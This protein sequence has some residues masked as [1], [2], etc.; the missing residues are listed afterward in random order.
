MSADLLRR[1]EWAAVRGWPALESREI[2]GWL[3][4]F[5]SG[6][7]IRANSVAALNYTGTDVGATIETIEA[8]YR[9]KN[10][11]AVFTVS[12]ASR[13]SD[14]DDRLAACGY[15]RGEDHITM[16]RSVLP[17][18]TLPPSCIANPSPPPGW[19]DAYLSGLSLDRRAIAPRLIANLPNAGVIFVGHLS[20]DITRTSGLTV[21][22]GRLASVQCMATLP[23]ARG[24]GGAKAVLAAIEATA[25]QHGATTLYLQTGGDNAAARALY[26]GAGFEIIGRYHTRTKVFAASAQT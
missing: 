22:D 2:D 23:T 17:A 18:T 4:R 21:I 9:S 10:A 15:A 8:L 19:M 7:S 12:D 5:T 20:N 6:G 13:P 11:P 25:L 1:I 3:W 16:A 24:R 26:A 14:L